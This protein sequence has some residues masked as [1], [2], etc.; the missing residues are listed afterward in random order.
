MEAEHRARN[1]EERTKR[2]LLTQK[3]RKKEKSV[4]FLSLAVA[5]VVTDNTSAHETCCCRSRLSA[6]LRIETRTCVACVV[7]LVVHKYSASIC[8]LPVFSVREH[9][10]DMYKN[11]GCPTLIFVIPFILDIG[12]YFHLSV[13]TMPDA[14]AG[15]TQ[16]RKAIR[17]SLTTYVLRLLVLSVVGKKKQS[18][19]IDIS[20]TPHRKPNG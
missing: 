9:G 17:R 20:T 15:V 18:I 3:E 13:Y 1:L 12:P 8:L 6:A 19:R 5:D 4:C 11:G 14:L 2:Q 10:Q 7:T 16:G